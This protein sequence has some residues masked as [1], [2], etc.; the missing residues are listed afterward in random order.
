MI[1]VV[2]DNFEVNLNLL[3][4]NICCNKYFFRK[5][6]FKGYCKVYF[7][8]FL[9]KLLSSMFIKKRAIIKLEQMKFL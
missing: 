2:N 6:L 8:F 5:Y 3:V 9:N 4:S 1:N 7:K